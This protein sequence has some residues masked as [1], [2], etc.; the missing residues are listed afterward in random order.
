MKGPVCSNI[1]LIIFDPFFTNIYTHLT[2]VNIC[3]E[4]FYLFNEYLNKLL[5]H[6]LLPGFS[7]GHV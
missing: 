1:K 3:I 6:A 4:G 5:V 2:F 7:L